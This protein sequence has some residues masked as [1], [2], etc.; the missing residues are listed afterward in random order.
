MKGTNSPAQPEKEEKSSRFVQR[1]RS[2]YEAATMAS[3]GIEMALSVVVGWAIGYWLDKQF[4]TSPYLMFVF[5]GFGIA[6]GFRGLIRVAKRASR[7]ATND[8][9]GE[10][11]E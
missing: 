1:W 8:G 6:A 11:N 3:V 4:D 7:D 5:L 9:T 2:T 10:S